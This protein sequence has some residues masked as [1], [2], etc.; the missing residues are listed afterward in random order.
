VA[1]AAVCSYQGV[2]AADVERVEA[3]EQF[4][5]ILQRVGVSGSRLIQ[6]ASAQRR[7]RNRERSIGSRRPS[8]A[9]GARFR[10]RQVI[11]QQPTICRTPVSWSVSD[12]A[13]VLISSKRP[14]RPSDATRDVIVSANAWTAVRHLWSPHI[15]LADFRHQLCGYS[16]P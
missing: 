12:S 8:R 10:H 16:H 13:P 5:E 11:P 3:L 4:A 1:R 7:S 6:V 15:S 9:T 14:L 2:G